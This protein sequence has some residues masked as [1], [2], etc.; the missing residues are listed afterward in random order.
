MVD[1]STA[2]QHVQRCTTHHLACD[3]REWLHAQEIKRLHA[4]VESAYAEGGQAVY[5]SVKRELSASLPAKDQAAEIARSWR[6][7]RAEKAL[8]EAK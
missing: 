1:L 2:P 5:R 6:R 8:K 7:S 3:C 4:L